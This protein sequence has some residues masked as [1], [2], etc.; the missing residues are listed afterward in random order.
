MPPN[1]KQLKLNLKH[2]ATLQKSNVRIQIFITGAAICITA[3]LYKQTMISLRKSFYG[4]L[5]Q[6]AELST[7]QLQVTLQLSP[8]HT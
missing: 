6:P 1:V 5:A 7:Y 3:T 4:R 8:F 2:I